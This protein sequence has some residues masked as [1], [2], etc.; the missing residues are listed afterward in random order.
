MCLGGWRWRRLSP[1]ELLI[2]LQL[3][4]TPL[5]GYEIVRK[6]REE[7]KGVWEPKTGTIYPAL[8]RLESR[9]LIETKLEEGKEYYHITPA[10]EELL[11][12]SL[13]TVEESLAFTGRYL[14]CILRHMPPHPRLLRAAA[15][16]IGLPALDIDQLASQDRKLA[17][18]TL[19][20][21]REILKARL[22]YVERKIQELE[23]AESKGGEQ[24]D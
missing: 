1:I 5:Y 14:S 9:G 16:S 21:I 7:F 4:K 2:L 11:R 24:A 13:L 12:E 3:R 23:Q 18:S 22:E 17:L 20:G 10:G 6:L 19:R 15:A 8:R